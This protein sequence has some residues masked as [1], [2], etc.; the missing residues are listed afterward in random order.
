[1]KK[2]VTRL[3]VVAL[4]SIFVL[5]GTVSADWVYLLPAQEANG[6]FSIGINGFLVELTDKLTGFIEGQSA[7][8]PQSMFNGSV[9]YDSSTSQRWTSWAESD[10]QRGKP[11]TWVINSTVDFTFDEIRIH[12]FCDA[13]G[14]DMPESIAFSYVDE[15]G[16]YIQ[17]VNATLVGTGNNK[18]YA[19]STGL[20]T[21]N[22]NWSNPTRGRNPTHFI[23]TIDNIEVHYRD[24]YTGVV[25]YTSFVLNN[26]SSSITTNVFKLTLDAPAG[27]FVGLVELE[28]YLNGQLLKW[29][30]TQ[31]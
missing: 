24:G 3:V 10:T 2:F 27:Y 30:N 13:Y 8:S 31:L 23:A 21:V 25:P 26:A 6:S 5:V 16:N 4:V 15:K 20:V 29:T 17:L 9:N 11:I 7:D 1:M 28:F 14:C 12:H 22:K 19:D 18:T